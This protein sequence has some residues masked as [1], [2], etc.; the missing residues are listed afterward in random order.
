M[1][2]LVVEDDIVIAEVIQQTLEKAGY[3][4]V[5]VT[6]I[7]KA[8]IEMNHNL[9]DAVLL[10]INLPDG[11][12]TR[13]TRL[14]RRGKLSTPILV[15][16]GNSSVDNRITALGSGADGY[17]TKP[18]DRDELIAHL[19]TIIRRAY[20]H[21]SAKIDVG[22]MMIDLN[23]NLI[24]INDNFVPLT[25]KEYQ[26]LYLL[27]M[28][29]GAVLSKHAFISHIYGG[30]DE[31][32][33]KIIDVFICKLRRKLDE[34]GLEKAKIETVWGQGYMLVD[35]KMNSQRFAG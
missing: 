16:S 14:I 25:H 15:V 11:D 7:E 35:E 24:T 20:G 5:H 27:G 28:R 26:I 23:R 2:I 3:H 9:I 22:N 21:S 29:K 30:I 12:G 6:T 4:S 1:N 8:L 33:S 17:L 13:L 19:E 18:F 34:W 32:D 10:D 31:P